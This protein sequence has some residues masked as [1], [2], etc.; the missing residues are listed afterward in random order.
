MSTPSPVSCSACNHT[1]MLDLA[2]YGGKKIRCSQ[3]QGIIMVPAQ[4]SAISEPEVLDDGENDR[5]SKPQGHGTLHRHRM[6][7]QRGAVN[8]A[9][10]QR[11]ED[12]REEIRTAFLEL[13]GD[14]TD[15]IPD[16]VIP[17]VQAKRA[18]EAELA[19]QKIEERI[20]TF[21]KVI[22]EYAAVR[23]QVGMRSVS[24]LWT[25]MQDSNTLYEYALRLVGGPVAPEVPPPLPSPAASSPPP[26]GGG[27]L[28][29][30]VSRVAKAMDFEAEFQKELQRLPTFQ[31][32]KAVLE[33][34]RAMLQEKIRAAEQQYEAIIEG[35][36]KKCRQQLRQ[37]EERFREGDVE[38]AASVLEE[39]Q[40]QSPVPLLGRVLATLSKCAYRAG[41][42][43]AAARH[44]QDAICFGASA[45]VD[46]DEGFH[47]LWAKASAGLPK[48]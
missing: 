8:I 27:L 1:Y 25:S 38:D 2:K 44:M 46:A 20:K 43:S 29:S 18:A 37:A 30:L 23:G 11:N 7:S 4:S 39:L 21:S 33:N 40:K 22:E 3:C 31:A 6:A 32:A 48:T 36:D 12:S 28:G 16:S 34:M 17:V 47:D 42:Q 24:D 35:H 19:E 41:N 13:H 14:E 15:R 45:P 9:L 26:L 10:L 5:P